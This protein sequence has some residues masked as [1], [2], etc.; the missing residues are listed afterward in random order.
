MILPFLLWTAFDADSC[1][2]NGYDARAKGAC[3]AFNMFSIKIP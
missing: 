3:A 1:N 2:F